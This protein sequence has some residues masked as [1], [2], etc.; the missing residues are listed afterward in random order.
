MEDNT[1]FEDVQAAAR[2]SREL[3]VPSAERRIAPDV[4]VS[5]LERGRR[6]RPDGTIE[7][8]ERVEFDR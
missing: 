6:Q 5:A 8:Y 7:E 2:F 4:Q 3:A 1:L